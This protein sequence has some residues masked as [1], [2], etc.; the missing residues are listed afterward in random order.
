MKKQS[1]AIL[2]ME[3]IVGLQVKQKEVNGLRKK[4]KMKIKYN[5]PQEDE[6][7]QKEYFGGKTESERDQ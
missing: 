4:L 1:K 6:D 5:V 7:E 3:N 2:N